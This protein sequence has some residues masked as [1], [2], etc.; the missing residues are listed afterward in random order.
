MTKSINLKI[1]TKKSDFGGNY[2]MLGKHLRKLNR[3]NNLK[4]RFTIK[5]NAI[6]KN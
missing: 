3:N 4:Q 2:Q 1:L 6:Y 5:N